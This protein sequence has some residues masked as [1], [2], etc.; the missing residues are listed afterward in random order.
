MTVFV[1]RSEGKGMKTVGNTKSDSV[2]CH[3][4]LSGGPCPLGE[5][6]IHNKHQKGKR[7]RGSPRGRRQAPSIQRATTSR[8][9]FLKTPTRGLKTTIC[10]ERALDPRPCS[11]QRFRP[12]MAVSNTKYVVFTWWSLAH[13]ALT[14]WWKARG[15]RWRPFCRP[16]LAD[17]LR[18]AI[19]TSNE[20]R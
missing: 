3:D 1:P 7:T 15:W 19:E 16:D 6:S 8:C 2:Q 18:H 4:Y 10:P 13:M 5:D 17:L 9:T 11:T 12:N 20:N 14:R